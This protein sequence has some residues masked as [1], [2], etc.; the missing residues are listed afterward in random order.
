ML[1][2][3]G[4]QAP[5]RAW[6]SLGHRYYLI[7]DEVNTGGVCSPVI[8]QMNT[9]VLYSYNLK[10]YLQYFDGWN[11]SDL[12]FQREKRRILFLYN[13]QIQKRISFIKRQRHRLRNQKQTFIKVCVMHLQRVLQRKQNFFFLHIQVTNSLEFSVLLILSK[14]VAFVE[15]TSF[16]SYIQWK[17]RKS[18]RPRLHSKSHSLLICRWKTICKHVWIYSICKTVGK[19]TG[20]TFYFCQESEVHIQWTL[21]YPLRPRDRIS[22]CSET[23][24]MSHDSDS[25]TNIV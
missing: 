9:V 13:L 8:L 17:L 15:H 25:I 6:F 5:C 12:F 14:N 1:T 10:C 22:E 24:A 4:L 20:M 23:K 21:Y 7:H 16:R 11:P 18:T 3:G 19:S 2:W